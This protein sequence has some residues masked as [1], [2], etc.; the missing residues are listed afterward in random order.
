MPSRIDTAMPAKT[1]VQRGLDTFNIWN[2]KG[3]YY[4]GLY[5]LFFLWLFA[6]TGLLLNHSSWKFAE[7]WPNR[8]VST[9]ERRIEGLGSGS[10][11]DRARDVMRQLGIMGEIEWAATRPGSTE[12]QF[13][14][15]KP[16][17]NINIVVHPGQ[18]RATVEQ[19]EVNAWGIAQVLHTFT[20]ARAVDKRNERDWIL[21]TVWVLSMDA[22]SAGLILMVLSGLY[23]WYGLPAKRVPGIAALLLGTV[24]CGVFVFGLRWIYS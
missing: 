24:I 9:M 1:P 2:R 13:R 4:L 19:T 6:F 17:H 22:V 14:V 12:F 18:D 8:K 11:L 5:F 16:G 21:T 3:H 23:M 10:D 15:N 20:G 7:F